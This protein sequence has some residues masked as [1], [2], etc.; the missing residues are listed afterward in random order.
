MGY[1][2]EQNI[3]NESTNIDR[4][5]NNM[6]PSSIE[7]KRKLLERKKRILKYSKERI[8]KRK[9]E[10]EYYDEEEEYTL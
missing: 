8:T 5:D 6:M 4:E 9:I 1:F 3:I 7:E 10:I 2:S